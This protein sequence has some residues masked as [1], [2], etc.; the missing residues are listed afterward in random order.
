MYALQPGSA[1]MPSAGRPF[2]AELITRLVA[3]GV[4]VAPLVLHTGVS[5]PERDEP[6]FPER[7]R[8]PAD[9]RA[10]RSTPRAAAAVIAVGTTVVRALETVA[11][12]DGTVHAGAGWTRLIVTPERPLRVV[13]GLVTG[14]HE[15][16]GLAPASCC[17]AAAGD[18]LLRR[19]YREALAAGYLWHEFGDSHLVLP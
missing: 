9:D 2:T 4:S 12:P 17:E 10:A 11:A 5:S 8:V 14:W 1:E 13:D 18:V 3:G 16:A 19:S 6:P 15:P 7:Y